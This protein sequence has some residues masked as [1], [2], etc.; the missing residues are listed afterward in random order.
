MPLTPS[1]AAD[2]VRAWRAMGPPVTGICAFNDEVAMAVLAGV[3]YLGLQAP[4]D[5]AVIGVDN[6]PAS[7][8]ACPPLTTVVQDVA[9]VAEHYADSV[10][11]AL[12][13][14]QA[15]EELIEQHIRLE[16]RESA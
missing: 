2:A 8:V 14:T 4:R 10:T 15:S 13:G 3:Q 9:A 6:S 16:V 5:I 1:G 11:A 12:A 7:A